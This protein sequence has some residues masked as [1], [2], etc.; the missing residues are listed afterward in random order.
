VAKH[1]EQVR[2]RFVIHGTL[3]VPI[4]RKRK[5]TKLGANKP[6]G[7]SIRKLGPEKE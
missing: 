2:V 4:V 3:L 6:T 5:R 7:V 1:Q